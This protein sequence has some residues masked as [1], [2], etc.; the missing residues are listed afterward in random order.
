MSVVITALPKKTVNGHAT[1]TMK[2]MQ[3]DEIS[4]A[5]RATRKVMIRMTP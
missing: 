5:E 4:D 2:T 3:N 1:Y